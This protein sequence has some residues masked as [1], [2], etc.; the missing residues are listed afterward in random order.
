MEVAVSMAD[1]V[2]N[3]VYFLYSPGD[4]ASISHQRNLI[5][6]RTKASIGGCGK[7]SSAERSD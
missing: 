3:D 5:F 6:S 1:S 7:F 4:C 2:I